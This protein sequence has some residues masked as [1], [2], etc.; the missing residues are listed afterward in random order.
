V[1]NADQLQDFRFLLKRRLDG[2][3]IAYILGVREFYGL[4]LKVTP[5]TLIPRPDTETLV[6]AAFQKIPVNGAWDILDL[7]TGTGAVALA[8]AKQRP[9]SNVIGVDASAEALA[10]AI[11]NAQSLGLTN[12]HFL[13]S[14]WFSDLVGQRFE[15]I[16]SN[17]PYIAEGD[18]HL[19]Q[20]DLRF[21]PRSAL[22]SG[23]DGLDD[24]RR[25]I[26]DAPN[27]LKPNGW[28]ML[29][30]GYDQAQSVAS[31]LKE[32]G[33]SQIDHTQDLAGTLRVTFGSIA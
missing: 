23:V 30:H 16:V 32:H 2:E 6:D 21:E 18:C 17:P 20:G 9:K 15:V 5:A 19:T 24:I 10:V 4:T 22:V 29:E 1:L 26:Q 28:L 8:I 11:E 7:G 31:L 14:D 27:Y 25:I 13:K 12:V 33:F 3:P